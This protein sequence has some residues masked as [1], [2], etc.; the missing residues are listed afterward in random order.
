MKT[1]LIVITT[2]LLLVGSFYAFNSYIYNEKQA[3]PAVFETYVNEE[4]GLSFEYRTEPDGYV[5]IP[6]NTATFEDGSILRIILVNK[7]E[8]EEIIATDVPREGPPSITFSVF[9]NL[10]DSTPHEWVEANSTVSNIQL[11]R[12]DMEEIDFNGTPTVRYTTDGLYQND[13]IV[14]SNDGRIFLITGS[15]DNP[16]SVVRYDFLEI[17]NSVSL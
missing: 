1:L 17:L 10:E 13:N 12:G 11:I 5:L 4:F 6:Q 15:Y 7:K 14:A 8:Y 9:E 3:D 2:V 16:E